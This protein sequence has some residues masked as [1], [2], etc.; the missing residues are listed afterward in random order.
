M[1]G[2]PSFTEEVRLYADLIDRNNPLTQ[3]LD[4][5]GRC[6]AASRGRRHLNRCSCASLNSSLG[7][8][9]TDP[10]LPTLAQR[11]GS[12]VI[13]RL[14]AT[15]SATTPAGSLIVTPCFPRRHSSAVFCPSKRTALPSASRSGSVS[16]PA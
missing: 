7:I 4:Q 6:F 2:P 10:A 15:R 13:R 9:S 8:R 12:G 16:S 1:T 3:S 5:L 14:W 11:E